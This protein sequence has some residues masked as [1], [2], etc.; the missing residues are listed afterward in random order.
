MKRLLSLLVVL[1]LVF[2]VLPAFP[3]AAQDDPVMK[4][5]VE[6]NGSL[7]KGYG[8]ISVDD[9][10]VSLVEKKPVVLLDVREVAEFEAGHIAGAIH[11]PIRTLMQN[12]N[13]LPDLNAEIVVV[14]KGGFRAAMAMAA[15]QILGYKNAKTLKGGFDAWVGEE[16]PVTQEV[17]APTPGTAPTFDETILKGLDTTLSGLSKS[18]DGVAPKDL[19]VELAENAPIL[20]DVRSDEE[21][22]KGYIEGAQHIWIDQFMANVD[23]LPTDKSAKIVIYCAAGYRGGI[24]KIMMNLMGYTNVRNISGGLN[25]WS[26]AGLPLVGVPVAAFDFDAYAAEYLKALPDTFGAMRVPDVAKELEV[27]NN[28]ITLVDVRT[29]DEYTEGHIAGAFNIPLNDLTKNLNLLP[30]LDANIIIYCGSGHRSAVAM[31]GLQLLGYKN[32][33]S[34]LSGATAWKAANLPLTEEAVTVEAGTAPTFNPDLFKLVDTYMTNIPKG[35]NVVKPADMNIALA[36]QKPFVLDVRGESEIANGYIEGASFVTLRDLI[37][38]ANQLPTDK[39]A[40]IF[41]Y[42]NP[43]HRSSIAMVL[44]GIRGYTNVKVLGGGFGAWEKASLPIKK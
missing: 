30:N 6:Y 38:K 34:M 33:R 40:P 43:T 42:D 14:C 19:A 20:I 21:F 28:G 25:G 3:A 35:Y 32:V 37:G 18:F 24:A 5:L 11:I 7:P 31:A 22:S 9:L 15:L 41:I 16:L 10:N 1:T 23:K 36:E 26:K 2:A 17:A 4:R 44:L 39:A 29:A 8:V 27:A 12:L 13:L